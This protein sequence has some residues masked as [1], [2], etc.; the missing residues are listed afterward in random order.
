MLNNYK[1][2]Q[3]YI[4]V[5]KYNSITKAADVLALSKSSV[6]RV[7][8]QIED[9]WGVQLLIR[10]TRNI[11]VTEAGEAVYRCFSR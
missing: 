10:S 2:Q 7:L 5:V 3:I 11:S 1:N 8:T 6:S 4:Q 9:E